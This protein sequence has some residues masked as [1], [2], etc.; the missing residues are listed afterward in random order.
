MIRRFSK[1]EVKL[2]KATFSDIDLLVSFQYELAK[3]T[4]NLLLDKKILKQ[5]ISNLLED[6]AKGMYWVAE[7]ESQKIGCVMIQKEWSDW[8]NGT[9]FWIHSVYVDKIYRKKGVF[10]S[11][12]SFFQEMVRNDNSLKGLRLYVDKTNKNAIKTYAAMGMSREHYDLY[13]WMAD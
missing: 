4:E 2:K 11:M 6:D 12:Y 1:M 13:E 7:I 10:R 5:G 8:R 9:V 3:E